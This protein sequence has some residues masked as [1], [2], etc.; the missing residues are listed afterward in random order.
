MNTKLPSCGCR[1]I[2]IAERLKISVVWGFE[3]PDP[4]QYLG[5]K[6]QRKFM[7]W[8]VKREKILEFVEQTPEPDVNN[9]ALN[10]ALYSMNEMSLWPDDAPMSAVQAI[11]AYRLISSILQND[12]KF[13]N[14]LRM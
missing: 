12:N 5:D 14:E 13:P 10:E 6:K 4:H 9:R 1:L 11:R 2:G 8:D 7:D 3:S